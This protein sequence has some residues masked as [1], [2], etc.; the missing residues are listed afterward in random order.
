MDELQ[1]KCKEARIGR[2][3]VGAFCTDV[4]AEHRRV[5]GGV[6]DDGA[7]KLDA[8]VVEHTHGV[9]LAPISLHVFPTAHARRKEG[10]AGEQSARGALVDAQ[11]AL[12]R[13]RQDPALV[14]AHRVR[15]GQQHRPNVAAAAQD[16]RDHLGG[17]FGGGGWGGGLVL[18]VC[19][20]EGEEWAGPSR[21]GE[22]G[23][24]KSAGRRTRVLST[25]AGEKKERW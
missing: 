17:E 5:L 4:A 22:G 23:A 25:R 1:R 7:R 19:V 18:C 13:Q 6:V 2:R 21:D 24:W 16:A 11:R 8:L 12:H 10:R 9:A 15:R 14:V 20:R 3:A